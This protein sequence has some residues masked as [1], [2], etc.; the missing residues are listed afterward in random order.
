MKMKKFNFNINR[1][2]QEFYCFYFTFPRVEISI[3]F[4]IL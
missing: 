2:V 3:L 4:F 1:L